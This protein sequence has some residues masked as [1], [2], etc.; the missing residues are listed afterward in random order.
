MEVFPEILLNRK[1]PENLKE[2][3]KPIFDP[4]ITG[5]A[6]ACYLIEL[7]NVSVNRELL[8][9]RKNSILVESF[10][11]P[12]KLEEYQS[13]KQ[14]LKFFIKNSIL[15]KNR[16]VENP[17]LWCLDNY[18][19][20][21]YFHWLTEILP[22]LWV[23]QQH[24]IKADFA[25]PDYFL[26]RWPF[27]SESAKAFEVERFVI[28]DTKTVVKTPKLILPTQTGGPINYQ[29]ISI[30]GVAKTLKDYFFD[31][32]FQIVSD[33]IYI[34]REKAKHRKILNEKYFILILIKH[35]F[36]IV[37]FETLDFKTQ[38]NIVARATHM[39]GIHGAGLTNCMF[40]PE[41]A[42]LLE[43]RTPERL[44]WLNCFYTLA[45][46]FEVKYSYFLGEPTK[47]KLPLEDR[48]D[49]K[50]LSIDLEKF[51]KELEIFLS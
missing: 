41:N 1:Y 12:N 5:L 18:S 30:K 44:S 3:D 40:Q 4:C 29:P 7:K 27:I 17:I 22:R 31:P 2:T 6:R 24:S 23:A 28:L 37:Q 46:V 43:I 42:K 15:R 8:I 11:W 21:G 20:G 19:T 47:E 39:V 9:F 33:K 26:E 38:L 10:V 36:Q 35:G 32:N 14:N 50:S 34:S 25:I 16:I 45:N 48:P 51:E 49:D 13:V